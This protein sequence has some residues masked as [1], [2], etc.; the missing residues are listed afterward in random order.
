MSNDQKI[1][2][3]NVPLSKARS[4]VSLGP[5]ANYE[6]YIDFQS[7]S[8][9]KNEADQAAQSAKDVIQ[10]L[11]KYGVDSEDQSD[12]LDALKAS[13]MGVNPE[14]N[15]VA[16][17]YV[18]DLIDTILINIEK[19]L[20]II[21]ERLADAI[22]GKT[23]EQDDLTMKLADLR[24]YKRN[25]TKFRVVLGPVEFAEPQKTEVTNPDT[26]EKEFKTKMKLDFVNFGDIPISVRYFAEF[27][28]DRVFNKDEGHYSLTRFLNDLFNNLIDNFLNGQKCFDFDISQKIR[29]N[30][31]VLT[32]YSKKHRGGFMK[33]EITSMLEDK[34]SRM[35]SRKI[36]GNPTIFISC[37]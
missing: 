23:Y 34:S 22:R 20:V 26:G 21:T 14:K 6:D 32:S 9:I 27:L 37:G 18:S 5:F 4:F 36:K 17:F 25:L 2:Y 31:N 3:V 15:Y 7:D 10:A 11:D 16:F 24:K 12:Q 8:F 13:L 33:D 29:V 1:Y 35:R 19:E 30:Q 28:A